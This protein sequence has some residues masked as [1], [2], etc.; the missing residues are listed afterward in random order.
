MATNTAARYSRATSH[1]DLDETLS[2]L[3]LE[4]LPVH[5]ENARGALKL[6]ESMLQKSKIMI[7]DDEAYNVLVVR[8][9]LQHTGYS[10]FVTTTD[11]AKAIELMKRDAPDVVLLD[12]TMPE[13]GGLEILR[14]MRMDAKLATIPV[15]ILAAVPEASAKTQALQLGAIDFLSKPV[16]LLLRVR[17]VLAAKSHF[18][19]LASYSFDL[20][21]QVRERTEELVL[22]RQQIIFCLARAAEFRDNETG[23]HVIRVGR[24]AGIIAAEIGFAETH[25][26]AIEL[27]AQL[28][29]VGK[30]G[31][32]D[33]ILHKPGK[34][35][36]EE[37]LL[38]KKHCGFGHQI[39]SGM[40]ED[41]WGIVKQHTE[42]GSQMVNVKT[43]PIMRLASRIALTHHE[44][45]NGAGYPL[46]LEG[47]DIPIEGRITA[48][49]DV[50]DALSSKR[51]YKKAFRRQK[52]FDML[53][54][55]RGTQFDPQ[56]LDAF[57][58]RSADIVEIQMRFADTDA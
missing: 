43:S 36:P 33:S 44:W 54:E 50:F 13:I 3:D 51:C 56:V 12:I 58:R 32:S 41:E 28:H 26:E 19:N 1:I 48:V 14:C 22:S 57:I 42:L 40:H 27:A 10:D 5:D 47:E 4:Q 9:F 52:C 38:V 21:R 8:K 37:F 20:E 31:I 17:N 55:K 7:I 39:I 29:D 2:L 34:L 23:H 18:D 6:D 25:V 35:D 46:G 45:W 15:I 53:E 30:I 11:S 16:E 24:Y 49:A